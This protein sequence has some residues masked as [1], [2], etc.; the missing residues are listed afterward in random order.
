MLFNSYIFILVF[1]PITLTMYFFLRKAGKWQ[2]GISMLV[3]ASLFYYG[4]WNPAYLILIGGSIVVN[5]SLGIG[6]NR[7]R[8]V[9]AGKSLLFFGVAANLLLLGYFKYIDF[10]ISSINALLG[11]EIELL[12]VALPLAISFFTF[13]QIAFLVDTYRGETSE[14]NF[15]DYCL[16]V[17][18]F[19]QLI[20]GPIVHHREML[21]QFST[22]YDKRVLAEDLSVGTTLFAFGLFKK[23]IL[24]D[25]LALFA[26]PVFDGSAGGDVPTM[27]NAWVGITAYTLQ[28]YFDFSGYSDMALGLGRMFGIVLPINFN[29]PYQATSV[30]DFWRRWHITLSRFLRDYLYIPL[31]GNRKGPARRYINLMLTMLLG[32][33]WHGAAW[34]FVVWGFLHGFYLCVNHVWDMVC[35]RFNLQWWGPA[36]SGVFVARLLT[37]LAVMVGWVFFRAPTFD[38]AWAMLQGMMGMGG[39]GVDTSVTVSVIPLIVEPAAY[40]YVPTLMIGL[41]AWVWFLPNSNQILYRQE[42]PTEYQ[43]QIEHLNPKSLLGR[44]YWRVNL[45]WAIVIALILVVC[46]NQLSKPSDF[47]YYIF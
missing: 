26:N 6:L 19:P 28:L 45:W 21:P 42:M 13:Q 11:T 36:W 44:F 18:F 35:K 31:G 23:V 40:W 30:V 20:A 29:S 32:G 46:L 9:F 38:G 3:I 2:L 10:S 22:N 43:T 7:T 14:Y 47:I 27:F 17:T 1:L 15:L 16:F 4:W 12:R 37:L 5:Y 8:E 33:L 41:L 25:N 39:F 34:T 24:A